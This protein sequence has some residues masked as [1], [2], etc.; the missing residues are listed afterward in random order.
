ML[1]VLLSPEYAGSTYCALERRWWWEAQQAVD[2]PPHTRVVVVSVR[3]VADSDWTGTPGWPRELCDIDGRPHHSFMFHD[4]KN[5]Q[6][7]T[8]VRPLGWYQH[9]PELV[10]DARK[11]LVRVAGKIKTKLSDIKAIV[12]ARE[13][14]YAMAQR[15][16]QTTGQKIFLHARD[17]QADVWHASAARL[18]AAGYAVEPD[19]PEL[20]PGNALAQDGAR[21]ARVHTLSTCDAALLIPP[22]NDSDFTLDLIAVGSGDCNAARSRSGRPLPCAV[23]AHAGGSSTQSAQARLLQVSWIAAEAHSLVPEV[24]AWLKKEALQSGGAPSGGR[25]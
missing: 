22:D 11:A 24:Q 19:G 16:D 12:E 20:L 14:S 3:P 6:D 9:E 8:Q 15:L 10:G 21:D 23:L 25:A 17:G 18:R 1:L 13:Q 7:E 4:G 5:V 2:L